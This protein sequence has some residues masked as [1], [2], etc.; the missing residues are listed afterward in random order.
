MVYETLTIGLRM[1]WNIINGPGIYRSCIPIRES[2]YRR[3]LAGVRIIRIRSVPCTIRCYKAC[4]VI[5]CIVCYLLHYG[6]MPGRISLGIFIIPTYCSTQRGHIP[7]LQTFS[8]CLSI[9]LISIAGRPVIVECGNVSQ[10]VK[11]AKGQV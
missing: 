11:P 3:A 4:P 5:I 9:P 2:F 10:L 1:S 8:R 7:C 6:S